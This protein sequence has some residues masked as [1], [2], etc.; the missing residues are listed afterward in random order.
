MSEE[1]KIEECEHLEVYTEVCGSGYRDR[2]IDCGN[3]V[4]YKLPE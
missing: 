2:C 4:E 1:E 3:I